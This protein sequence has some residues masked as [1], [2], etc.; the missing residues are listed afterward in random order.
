MSNIEPMY[1]PLLTFHIINSL[2]C[3]PLVQDRLPALLHRR[4]TCNRTTTAKMLP[5]FVSNYKRI[6]LQRY[7]AS[8]AAGTRPLTSLPSTITTSNRTFP[9]LP[10]TAQSAMHAHATEILCGS[11]RLRLKQPHPSRWTPRPPIHRVRVVSIRHIHTQIIGINGT[12]RP[13]ACIPS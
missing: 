11:L 8:V 13:P 9:S 1:V 2:L 12:H 7:A 4:Y 5:P 10:K 6:S 3:R